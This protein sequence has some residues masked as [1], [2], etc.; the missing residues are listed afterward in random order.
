MESTLQ[1]GIAGLKSNHSSA[2]S[3]KKLSDYSA[4]T[5]RFIQAE[6]RS[7]EKQIAEGTAPLDAR[8]TLNLARQVQSYR[9]QIEKTQ[10]QIPAWLNNVQNSLSRS[11]DVVKA[12]L[13][14]DIAKAAAQKGDAMRKATDEMLSLMKQERLL[15]PLGTSQ[16]D[17]FLG[18]E[19]VFKRTQ[20]PRAAEEE[21]LADGLAQ[22]FDPNIY[23]PLAGVKTLSPE[24]LGIS[25]LTPEEQSRSIAFRISK[26]P[27][28]LGCSCLDIT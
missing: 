27:V 5:K 14:K 6:V 23:V 26:I 19:V 21:R 28:T 11:A 2:E 25:L 24:R 12:Q 13:P 17:V 7:L 15:H 20:G 1:K 18:S 9:T 22:I 3:I 10:G 16:Q 4:K 8:E